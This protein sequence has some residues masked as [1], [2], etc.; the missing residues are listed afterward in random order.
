M[1]ILIGL[2]G[3]CA[4]APDDNANR[5]NAASVG[6]MIFFKP[7]DIF[8]MGILRKLRFFTQ[9]TTLQVE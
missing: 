1:I 8:F 9:D 5:P 7:F 3:Y 6:A 4:C 2:L